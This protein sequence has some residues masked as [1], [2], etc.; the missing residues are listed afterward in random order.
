MPLDRKL[1]L[2][3]ELPQFTSN[4]HSTVKVYEINEKKIIEFLDV[5]CVL[6]LYGFLAGAIMRYN[7]VP[8]VVL[9]RH[10]CNETVQNRAV[11][12]ILWTVSVPGRGH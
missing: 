10:S 6:D 8:R 2:C 3:N 12:E 11:S 1:L 5:Q 7:P 4:R 9:I